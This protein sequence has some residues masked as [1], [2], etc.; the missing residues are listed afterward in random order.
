MTQPKLRC[1]HCGEFLSKVID[2]RG[3]AKTVWRRRRCESCG[4][5]FSTAEQ[6]IPPKKATP[7]TRHHN[8]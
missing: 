3:N 7:K 6:V 4:K 8:I 1:P 2:S 5:K